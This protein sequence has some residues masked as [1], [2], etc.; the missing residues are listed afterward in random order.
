M[1]VSTRSQSKQ[2]FQ[3]EKKMESKKEENNESKKE[4][5]KEEK[6][7]LDYPV[8]SNPRDF[9]KTIKTMLWYLES[10]EVNKYKMFKI[11]KCIELYMY[12]NKNI[13]EW[14]AENNPFNQK[15]DYNLFVLTIIQKTYELDTQV[16]P[17]YIVGNAEHDKIK[18]MF[19][20]VLNETRIILKPLYLILKSHEEYDDYMIR[21]IRLTKKEKYDLY[22]KKIADLEEE[23][24]LKLKNAKAEAKRS[25]IEDT[26]KNFEFDL[27]DKIPENIPA[28][29]TTVRIRVKPQVVLRR[30]T[31]NV[32]RY[33]V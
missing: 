22:N 14:F 13:I 7:V 31:R 15:H 10:P 25:M 5:K 27:P 21:N 23:F 4:S 29:I 11:E 19:S 17:F 33:I 8:M 32:P 26:K 3:E 9:H 30:S 18:K 24:A 2:S 1:P 16:E 28:N 20:D 6:S 12:I